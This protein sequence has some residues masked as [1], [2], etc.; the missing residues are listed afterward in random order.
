MT[1]F[2]ALVWDDRDF[3]SVQQASSTRRLI[4]ESLNWHSATDRAGLAVFVHPPESAQQRPIP[5]HQDAGIVLGT[6]FKRSSRSSERAE[7]RSTITERQT[8]DML[9]TR[10]RS[11]IESDWGSY[12]LFL[13]RAAEHAISVLRGPAGTLPCYYATHDRCCIF[14]SDTADFLWLCKGRFSINWDCIRAQAAAGDYITRETG[15]CEMAAVISGECLDIRAGKITIRPYWNPTTL[16]GNTIDDF[17]EAAA[18]LRSETLRCVGAWASVHDTV[19]LLLSGG[20]D[21][22]VVLSC[23]RR[24]HNRTRVV[25]VN[26]YSPGPG[27]ERRFA[28]SMATRTDTTLEEIPSNLNINL[29]EFLDCALT[30]SPVLNFSAFDVEPVM[31]ALAR[32]WNATAIFTGETGD[33]VFGRAPGPEALAEVLQGRDHIHRFPGASMDYAELTRISVWHAMR[34]AYQYTQWVRR[35]GTWSVYHHRHL[36]GDSNE[37]Y[38]IS[39]RAVSEYESMMGRFSHPWFKEAE[40]MPLGKVMLIYSLIKATSSVCHSPFGAAGD[41]PTLSPLVSQPL[42]ETTLR[43]PS[44]MHYL[45]AESGAVAR[46]AFRSALSPDVLDRGCGKGIPAAWA[47]SLLEGNTAFLRDLL[48]DGVLAQKGILDR[49]KTQTLL[50]KGISK[51]RVGIADLIRQ[52]YIETWLRRWSR[53][54]ARL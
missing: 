39:A 36:V 17:V 16:A 12:I 26:F 2:I 20:F 54:G 33:D 21:S 22:S 53:E 13:R 47:R 9:R 6:L 24:S 5:L 40:G 48:L 43:V 42:L 15:L 52:I 14:V 38:L 31:H 30:P 37:N 45:R 41:A 19:L 8:N 23:L 49:Q 46:A 10:G 27:D 50:S 32:T 11:L 44:Y 51:A 1:R 18:L 7:R 3:D 34:L 35:I 4:M 29:R 28:R 25:A